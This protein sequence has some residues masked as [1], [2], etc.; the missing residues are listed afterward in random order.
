[1]PKFTVVVPVYN[2]QDYIDECVNSILTQTF[3]DWELVLVDDGSPDN[4]PAICDAYAQKDKRVK[5]IHKTNG[6]LS[7]ARNCGLDNASG[8]YVVFMDS[9]D[10]WNQQN[11][12]ERLNEQ[13]ELFNSDIVIFGCTDFNNKTGETIVSRT[14]Y[15]LDLIRSASKEETLHYL[16]STKMIPGGATIF[17]FRRSLCNE[18]G[19]RFHLG[20]QD[21]DYDF[22]MGIFYYSKV[23]S[24][25]DDPFY[26]YRHSRDGSITGTSNI[27]MIHGIDYTVNKWFPITEKMTDAVIRRDYQN[28]LAF[29]YTTGFVVAGRMSGDKKKDAIALMKKNRFILKYG[30]WKKTKLTKIGSAVCGMKLFAT[31]AAKYF[32]RTHIR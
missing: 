20:I 10:Y 7:D 9:D 25:I 24:A 27:N 32:D 6:G 13:I 3:E 26:S 8:D 23:I 15:N 31:L 29:V 21:E 22:V 5:V 16:M 14:G 30:Y 11:A 28:Y 4:C 19:I 17:A 1:M 2:V 12:F 18:H